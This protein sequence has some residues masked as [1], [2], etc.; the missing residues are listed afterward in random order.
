[1]KPSSLM[2]AV[3][4]IAMLSVTG[5][6]Q[7]GPLPANQVMQGCRS[8]LAKTSQN[9][10][11]QGVCFRAVVATARAAEGVNTCTPKGVTIEQA[12]RVVIAYID[13]Q[14]ASLPACTKILTNLRWKR[15][16]MLGRASA[17]D[18]REKSNG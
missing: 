11:S 7:E 5:R 6:A 17:R 12:I 15:S 13:S 1:M 4:C 2:L 9:T 16:K 10:T 14:P 3:A 8:Y 18:V